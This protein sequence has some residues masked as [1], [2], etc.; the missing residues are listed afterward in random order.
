MSGKGKI[1]RGGRGE[2]RR[3]EYVGCEGA[4]ERGEGIGIDEKGGKKNDPFSSITS[5]CFFNNMTYNPI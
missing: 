4:V 3:G 5:Y 2:R 1:R